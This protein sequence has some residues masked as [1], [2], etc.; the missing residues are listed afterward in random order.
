M[1]SGAFGAAGAEIVVED[2]LTGAEASLFAISDGERALVFG[3]AQDHKRVG[4]GDTGPNTGGMGAYSP[5]PVLTP[6]VV[7]RAMREIVAPTIAGMASRQTPFRGMLFAG[8]MIG[9]DG[10]NLIE[11]NV[12]FGDPEAEAILAR[13]DDDVLDFLWGAS[14]GQ[15]PTRAPVFAKETALTVI[16][17]A[18]GYPGAVD[19]GADDQRP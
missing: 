16:M 2:F 1:F 7:E 19:R 15:L 6:E 9:A 3:G 14:H 12:R 4:D 5:A 8:L 18:R 13:L 17:A 10:P 11:F